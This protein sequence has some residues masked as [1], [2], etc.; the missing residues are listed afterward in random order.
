MPATHSMEPGAGSA[1]GGGFSMKLPTTT[2]GKWA[3]WLAVA[4]IVGFMLNGVLVGVV[5]TST[6]QAVNDFSSTYL[7]YWG[8]ALMGCGFISGIVG[9]IAIVKDRERSIV[10]LL[11]LIPTL[12]VAMFLLGEILVPH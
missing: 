3:M 7:P 12:F 5:G 11:T 1:R 9:L 8:I 6:N 2:L 10:V 4:F